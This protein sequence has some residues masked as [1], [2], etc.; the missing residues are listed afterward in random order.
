MDK[1]CKHCS[2]VLNLSCFVPSTTTKSGYRGICKECHNLYCRTRRLEKYE[3]VRSYEKKFH[4]QRRLRYEYN[5]TEEQVEALFIS[6]DYKCK[7]CEVS[8]QEEPLVIDHCHIHKT[9]RGLLCRRCNLGIGHFKDNVETL[10][11]AIKYLNGSKTNLGHVP[12]S[13]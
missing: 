12:S 4:R 2:K 7:I 5:L 10:D 9:V 13:N 6:Q 11:K 3:L 1:V 8:H